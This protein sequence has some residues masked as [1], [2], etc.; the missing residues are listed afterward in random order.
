VVAEL[1]EIFVE[2][3]LASLVVTG[4]ALVAGSSVWS[5][6][7]RHKAEKAFLSV[8]GT[9]MKQVFSQNVGV[10]QR[11]RAGELTEEEKNDLREIVREDLSKLDDSTEDKGSIEKALNQPSP[12]G[13]ANYERKLLSEGARRALRQLETT[14]TSAKDTTTI[15]TQAQRNRGDRTTNTP[16]KTAT[17]EGTDARDKEEVLAVERARDLNEEAQRFAENLADSYRLVYGQ[18]TESAERQQ[19]RA[20]EF[21]DLVQGNLEEQAEAGRANVQQLTERANRQQE[22]GQKFAR[23]SVEA[24]TQF[25]NDAFSQYRDDTEQATDVTRQE[26]TDETDRPWFDQDTGVL[27]IDEYIVKTDSYKRIVEDRKITDTELL[28]QTLRVVTLLRQLEEVLSPEAKALATEAFGEM[29][30]LNALQ[31]LRLQAA[32]SSP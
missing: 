5:A 2:V 29:A 3:L 28:E 10:L 8:L 19:Q 30:V 18:A 7:Q 23:E 22:A 11:A 16:D 24:Y 25:L 14:D 6:I 9:S 21:S 26:V 31:A 4:S 20:Q 1:S 27:L 17:D 12:K 13:R 32:A 15:K